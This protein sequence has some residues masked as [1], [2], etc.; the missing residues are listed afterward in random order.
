MWMQEGRICGRLTWHLG[1]NEFSVDLKTLV[2]QLR[3]SIVHKMLK[4]WD[5]ALSFIK[6]KATFFWYATYCGISKMAAIDLESST[7]VKNWNILRFF[8][9]KCQ[10]VCLVLRIQKMYS[11]MHLRCLVFKLHKIIGQRPFIISTGGQNLKLLRFYW[12]IPQI[13]CI[14]T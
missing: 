2:G 5:F 9:K 3:P 7:W 8:W 12:N 10:I 1:K 11:L 13:V 4:L 6:A 14:N